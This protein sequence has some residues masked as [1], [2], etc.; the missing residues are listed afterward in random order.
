[1]GRTL[2]LKQRRNDH[3]RP[4]RAT[5]LSA[6]RQ[7]DNEVPAYVNLAAPQPITTQ[8]DSDV[9]YKLDE[10]T[11]A[12]AEAKASLKAEVRERHEAEKRVRQLWRRL[13]IAQEEER[14]RIA[15]DLHDHIGQQLTALQLHLAALGRRGPADR[16]WQTQFEQT[17]ESLEQLDRDLDLF[18]WE[19]RPAAIYDLGLAPALTD[20][21]AGFAKNYG[22][23]ANFEL[24]CL[25]TPRLAPETEINLYRIAQ[26]AL[27]NIHKHAGA[28]SIDVFLQQRDKHIVL[29]IIDNGRGF[30]PRIA[31]DGTRG[32]GLGLLGMRERASLIGATISIETGSRGTSVIVTVP[33]GSPLA[34]ESNHP[35]A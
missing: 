33:A 25:A 19:L 17:Q 13:I 6:V 16:E 11:R 18:T 10:R 21:V 9:Q 1:V 5:A 20:F 15:R 7:V 30:D 12:L 31:A 29:S 4:Y 23:R 35:A 22:I 28:T 3:S 32:S 26:E 27:N 24:L 8:T 34:D 2:A 14:R